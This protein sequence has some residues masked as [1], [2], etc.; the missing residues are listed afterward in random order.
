VF[1][2]QAH[3]SFDFLSDE[4]A[5]LF[6]HSQATAF[7][8]PVWL[9][10]LYAKLAPHVGAQP[11][12]MTVRSRADGRLALLLPLLRRRRGAMRAVEFACFCVCGLAVL[13]VPRDYRPRVSVQ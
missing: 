9:D 7:Q 4:Y 3:E 2:V 12:I 8:H 5:E 13:T 10:R 1:V 11:L 6:L